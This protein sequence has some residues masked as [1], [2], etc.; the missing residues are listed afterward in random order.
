MHFGRNYDDILFPISEEVN[1]VLFRF[2]FYWTILFQSGL[3]GASEAIE[4]IS[5]NDPGSELNRCL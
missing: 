3:V 1:L 2:L 4:Q 5:S